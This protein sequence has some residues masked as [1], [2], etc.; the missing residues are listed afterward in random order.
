VT[1]FSGFP[2]STLCALFFRAYTLHALPISSSSI[3]RRIQLMKPLIIQ[4]S[5][6]SCYLIPPEFKH[7]TQHPVRQL[8]V[9][10]PCQVDS[11]SPRHGASSSC[12]WRRLPPDMKLRIHWISCRGQPTSGDTPTCG[13]G[14]GLKLLT[15]KNSLS[16]VTQAHLPGYMP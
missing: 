16:D 4:F 15:I 14:V 3:R 7:F 8:S 11:L 12:V 13:L 10:L 6:A 1:L 9:N 5:Q 2:C